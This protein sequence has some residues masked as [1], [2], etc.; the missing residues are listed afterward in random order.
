MAGGAVMFGSF[1]L[2]RS[3]GG[4]GID[5]QVALLF[6]ALP[7]G[8][9]PILAILSDKFPIM[10]WLKRYQYIAACVIGIIASFSLTGPVTTVS[11]TAC[12]TVISFAVM[13]IDMLCEG[14]Y[15]TLMS[16]STGDSS[17]PAFAWKC[18]T[19]G[20]LVS[21]LAVG[22]SGD[23]GVSKYIIALSGI[24][25]AQGLVL[26]IKNPMSVFPLG[27]VSK[28]RNEELE[29]SLVARVK[30]PLKLEVT[31]QEWAL[32]FSFMLVTII[33]LLS[34]GI[35]TK[36]PWAAYVV[37]LMMTALPVSFLISS[38]DAFGSAFIG[39]CLMNMISEM[40][41]VDIS[42]ATS[43]W[44]TQTQQCAAAGP[45]FSLTF[46]V[47]LSAV[48]ACLSGLLS[49]ALYSST[50][51]KWTYRSAFNIITGMLVVSSLPDIIM[52][53]R[54]NAPGTD[55]ILFAVGDAGLY[56][57]AQVA[58][59]ICF[60]LLS[61]ELVIRG[62]E[63]TMYSIITGFQALGQI[64]SRLLGLALIQEMDIKTSP[65]R[66][67]FRYYA[68]LILIGHMIIPILAVCF[69]YILVADTNQ[70]KRD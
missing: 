38:K 64:A 9:R 16:F 60:Y 57:A 22:P 29:E 6:M 30:N 59:T 53:K 21:A 36:Y 67:T 11:A 52:A 1:P 23:S 56:P 55:G 31:S 70:K 10:G 65:P 66:C 48:I 5:Y 41:Y 35:Q 14:E 46:Y 37:C 49:A 7:W 42:G 58:R 8:M 19:L 18:T 45:G 32:C 40:T 62:K 44:F 3:L 47:S 28:P 13:V 39:V 68:W 24:C 17:M 51:K 63:T 54:L 69:S 15:C 33:M 27:D 34:L 4:S 26:G 43:F 20:A 25:F 50:L 12:L 61:S 2:I